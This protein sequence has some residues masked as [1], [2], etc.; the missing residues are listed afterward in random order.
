MTDVGKPNFR[1]KADAETTQN[2]PLEHELAVV[3]LNGK[4]YIYTGR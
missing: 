2:F 3:Y 4:T 1:A